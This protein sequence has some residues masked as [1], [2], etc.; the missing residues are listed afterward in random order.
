MRNGILIGAGGLAV[1]IAF[2]VFLFGAKK[3][4]PAGASSATGSAAAGA[5]QPNL[6]AGTASAKT[7]TYLVTGTP[8]TPVTYG[9][10]GSGFQG[11]APVRAT[12]PIGHPGYYAISA[13]LRARGSVQ[14]E[15]LVGKQVISNSVATGRHN[16]VSCEISR[17]PQTGN[18]AAHQ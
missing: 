10:G 4:A 18:W 5:A 2:G 7:I 6:G 1:L 3:P 15:I 11:Q 9:P 12:K 8:G 14:C 16:A 13:R 17:N